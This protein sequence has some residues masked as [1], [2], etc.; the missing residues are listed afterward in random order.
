MRRSRP[1]RRVLLAVGVAGAVALFWAALPAVPALKAAFVIAVLGIGAWAAWRLLQAFLW[2]VGRRLAFSYFLIGVLPIPMVFIL[3]LFIAYLTAGFVLGHLYRDTVDE[4]YRELRL[5]AAARLEVLA[6]GG[7]P[8]GGGSSGL[9]LAEYR[10]GRRV[11]GAD[12]APSAWPA[13]LEEQ[14][15]PPAGSPGEESLLHYVSLPDGRP[16]LAAALASGEHGVLAAFDGPIEEQ[17]SARREISVRLLRAEEGEVEKKVRL[18]IGGREFTLQPAVAGRP[19]DEAP[20]APAPPAAA[21]LWDRPILWWGELSGPLRS[22]AD[23]STLSDYLV[24]SL[25]GT[26]RAVYRHL[27]SRDA[28]LETATWA[29]LLTLA[30]LL[31]TIYGSAVLMALFMIFALSRAVNRLSSATAA[32]RAGD[33]AVRIPV[34]RRDQIGELQRSFNQMAENL[35]QSVAAAAQKEVLDKELAIARDLQKSLLPADLPQ[36]E[37]VEF[38]TLFEPSAAIG[39]DYFDVLPI[40]DQRLAVVIADVSGHGLPTGLRMA[41]LKAALTLLVERGSP[42]G[43]ILHELDRMVRSA[44]DP[45]CF[46]TLTIALLDVRSGTLDLT[47]A[48]HPPTYLVRRGTVEEIAL[49][50]PPLGVLGNSYG[51]SVLRLEPGDIVV[52]LSDGLIEAADGAG[53]PFGYERVR[54]ALAGDATSAQ[55]VRDRLLARVAAHSRG[56]AEDDRTLL[57]LGYR[58]ARAATR[59]GLDAPVLRAE[60][61]GGSAEGPL[62]FES[63]EPPPPGTPAASDRAQLS[64]RERAPATVLQRWSRYPTC[65]LGNDGFVR[66]PES[67]RRLNSELTL[68][69]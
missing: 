38:A 12:S 42:P 59:A 43:E 64:K 3:F 50:G 26:P 13:W 45:R 35:E 63:S 68:A 55:E 18:R 2:R 1:R 57:A 17:L 46:V 29:G 41:M 48:G 34:R 53:E 30:A 27:F 23:G 54:Q 40:D 31:A 62:P 44:R 65:I 56:P 10:N 60:P 58:L 15:G 67:R 24:A 49:A 51:R 66:M 9:L 32:V 25:N 39:G 5:T 69:P 6:R 33:F 37:E 19:V 16:T 14:Q 21:K 8:G 61:D 36:T 11:A 28:E 7:P 20:P 22:L 47:N 4:L 52:W